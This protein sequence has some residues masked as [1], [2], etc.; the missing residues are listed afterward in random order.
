MII[1]VSRR[2]DMPAFYSEWPKVNRI[3]SVISILD[4]YGKAEKR[5]KVLPQQGKVVYNK[6]LVCH[7]RLYR[8]PKQSVMS[9]CRRRSSMA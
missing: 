8:S 7:F 5:L 9:V 4:I 3:Y 6:N 1:S 2:T